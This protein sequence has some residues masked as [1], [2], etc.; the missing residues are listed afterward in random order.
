[1][2]KDVATVGAGNKSEAF[3]IV[4]EFDITGF[5]NR[6]RIDCGSFEHGCF[7]LGLTVSADIAFLSLLGVA[8]GNCR[9]LVKR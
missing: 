4:K 7:G 2:D 9:R 1:M 3:E 6:L 5:S 8:C